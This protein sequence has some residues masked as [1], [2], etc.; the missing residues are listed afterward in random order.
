MLIAVSL[1]SS[2]TQLPMPLQ[3][4]FPLVLDT[5]ELCTDA[6]KRDLDGPREALTAEEDRKAGLE[7]AAKRAKQVHT[8]RAQACNS[9]DGAGWQSCRR[10][11][12]V[13]GNGIA[14]RAGSVH[15]ALRSALCATSW[16]RSR[17]ADRAHH[18]VGTWCK[19]LDHCWPGVDAP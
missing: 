5:Y 3:V 7:K 13:L 1:C 18:R 11:Q 9:L 6:Y 14:G 17:H 19:R 10:L 4:V 15:C 8:Y 16:G 2:A 12:S